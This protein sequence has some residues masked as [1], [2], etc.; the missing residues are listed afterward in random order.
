MQLHFSGTRYESPG[1]FASAV[2]RAIEETSAVPGVRTAALSTSLPF[3]TGTGMP[4]TVEGRVSDPQAGAGRVRYVG[5]TAQFFAAMGIRLVGGRG[6]E[7][8]DRVSAPLVAVIN[9]TAARQYWPGANAI[10]QRI[11]IGQPVNPEIADPA[12]R[13]IVGIV[14]DVREFAMTEEAPPIVYVPLAQVPPPFEALFKRLLPFSLVM[15][16]DQD[17]ERLAQPVQSAVQRV[18]SMLPITGVR[19]GDQLLMGSLQTQQFNTLLMGMLALVALVLA[20]TGIYGVVSCLVAQRTSEIGVRLALGATRQDVLRLM[21]GQGLVPA[22]IGAVVGVVATL[23]SS[24][25]LASLLF[26]SVSSTD[27]VA[28]GGGSI[29]VLLMAAAAAYIP[30]RRASKLDPVRSLRV[31]I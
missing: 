19:T 4:F 6:L 14:A 31:E 3:G 12:P 28:L 22:A 16:T 9:E 29:G 18:D 24:R 2:T 15:R 21:I 27:P 1:T 11:T 17:A 10:G 8:Q 23:L 30:A 13:E 25:L 20:F 5:A 26:G 7:P